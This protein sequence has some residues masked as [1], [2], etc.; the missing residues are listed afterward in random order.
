MF[1]FQV[2]TVLLVRLTR[3]P[4]GAHGVLTTL[5]KPYVLTFIISLVAA[6]KFHQQP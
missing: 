4:G 6:F 1:V 5:H 3:S 2:V